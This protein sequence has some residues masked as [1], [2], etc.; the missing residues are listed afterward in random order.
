MWRFNIVMC[1]NFRWTRT[2]ALPTLIHMNRREAGLMALGS[3][4]S[5]Q[6]GQACGKLLAAAV[7]P[8]GVIALRLA[9]AALF[10]L[11]FWRPRRPAD[12]RAAGLAVAL[13][14]SIAGMS[15]IYPALQ[16]LPVGIAST[17]QF[18]G[19]LTLALAGSRRARDAGCALLAGAGVLIFYGP[20]GG[21]PSVGG[22]VLALVSGASM[23][24]Y[25]V[26]NKRA[27][28]GS[29]LAWAALIAALLSL[30]AG[31][32][33]G[34]DLL[35]A[36]TLLAAAGIGLSGA[37][38]WSLDLAVLRRLPARA[39][40]VTQ[41]LEPAVGGLAGLLLLGEHLTWPQW[42]AIG[43]I[44]LAS[45]ASVATADVPRAPPTR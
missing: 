5:V 21:V 29:L 40:A 43:C 34:H 28:D 3:V 16:R 22:G 32:A 37:V 1:G 26:L 23:A 38:S 25:T 2:V 44:M 35:G 4:V 27:G 45:L 12:A 13:G 19:P 41:S 15:A 17:L 33:A 42:S 11:A 30:P 10:L 39:V 31:L 6:G 36:P 20:G 14:C 18:L 7:G 9:F 24:V 8:F